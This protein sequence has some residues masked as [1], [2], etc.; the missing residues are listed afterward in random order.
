MADYCWHFLRKNEAGE[1]VLRY[2]TQA[3][4]VGEW[5]EFTGE[6]VICQSGLHASRRAIDALEYVDW[7]DAVACLVDVDAVHGEQ[8]NK[9]V[10]SRR[11]IVAM[12]D[13]DEVL[14]LFARQ[15]ALGVIHLWNPPQVV[16]E[17]LTTGDESL[18]EAA[19]HSAAD[20][21]AAAYAAYAAS[22]RAAHAAAPAA[23]SDAADAADAAA[24]GMLERML[25]AEM[26]LGDEL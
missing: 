13:A 4:Q 24:A 5:L 25:L 17:Y 3:P 8:P 14:R 11:R 15:C 16:V 10:C 21:A 1:P 2:G 20:A 18:R 12:C 7:S 22:A 23:A 6:V 19:H 9:L 26:N